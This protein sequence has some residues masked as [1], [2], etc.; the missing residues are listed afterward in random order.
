MSE[1]ATEGNGRVTLALLR[2]DIIDLKE[3]I[4]ALRASITLIL[5]DHEMRLRSNEKDSVE[6]KTLTNVKSIAAAVIG[7]VAGIAAAM[8]S[9]RP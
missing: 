4:V 1:D 3:E 8:F 5:N 2:R 7:G 9:P 6:L